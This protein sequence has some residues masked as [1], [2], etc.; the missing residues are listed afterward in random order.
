M[1]P[2]NTWKREPAHLNPDLSYY[3]RSR[4]NFAEKIYKS[5]GV[6]G[7][8]ITPRRA[9][10]GKPWAAAQT[11]YMSSI[12]KCFWQSYVHV[13]L[14]YCRV[15]STAP[16]SILH[17]HGVLSMMVVFGRVNLLPGA[18]KWRSCPANAMGPMSKRAISGVALLQ[19]WAPPLQRQHML[20]QV[21]TRQQ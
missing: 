13:L 17:L 1:W 7:C 14:H 19:Q 11:P 8:Q 10:K 5:S 16:A 15:A 18:A 12:N 3:E 20:G 2:R 21:T 6:W 4:Q 9:T